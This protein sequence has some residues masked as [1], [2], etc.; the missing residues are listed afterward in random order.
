MSRLRSPKSFLSSSTSREVTTMKFSSSDDEER[1]IIGVVP[2]ALPCS[3]IGEQGRRDETFDGDP[4]GG[5]DPDDTDGRVL[6]SSG[7]RLSSAERERARLM[8]LL[9]SIDG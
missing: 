3:N 9:S 6:A 7:R 4:G 5:G 2:E 1:S 8:P